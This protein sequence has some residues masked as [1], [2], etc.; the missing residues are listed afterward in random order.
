MNEVAGTFLARV[1][2]IVT[3]DWRIT[4]QARA[5]V[6]EAI[7]QT[8]DDGLPRACTPDVFEAKA[9]RGPAVYEHFSQLPEEPGLSGATS[10]IL[11]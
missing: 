10:L 6:R 7:E 5:R 8:L 9:G 11:G 2:A 1:R 3:V 4:A